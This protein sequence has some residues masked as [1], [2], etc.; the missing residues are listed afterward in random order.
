MSDFVILVDQ[1]D[2]QIGTMPK[3]EAHQKGVLHRA[4]SIFIFNSKNEIL[5][6]QRAL[7]KYHSAGLWSNTCCSHPAPNES[8][9]AAANRRLQEEMGMSCQMNSVFS[10]TY[11]A[12]FGN[13]LIEH[14]FDYVFFGKSDALPSINRN[15]VNDWKYMSINTLLQDIQENPALYTEWLKDCLDKVIRHKSNSLKIA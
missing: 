14:E 10:F 15:E 6:Q 11:K 5:M 13:G 9:E 3:L 1:N 4:F 12:E 7:D 2:T 8:N